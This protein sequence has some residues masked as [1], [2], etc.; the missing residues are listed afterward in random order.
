MHT[1]VAL[2]LTLQE[3][4]EV[5]HRLD[6]TRDWVGFAA[7]GIFVLGAEIIV[8]QD[9]PVFVLLGVVAALAAEGRHFQQLL[10][11]HHVHDLEAAADDEGAAEQLL[12]FF[13]RRVGGDV[14][15]FWFHPEQQVAHGAAHHE[16][17]EARFLQG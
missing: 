17:L 10:A 15:V 11:E 16:G 3:A 13:R 8:A 12:Y 1:P 4:V 9:A 5:P 14:E 6:L 2:A 7:L